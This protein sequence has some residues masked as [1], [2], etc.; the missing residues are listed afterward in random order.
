M[1]NLALFVLIL[2]LLEGSFSFSAENEKLYIETKDYTYTIDKIP[3]GRSPREIEEFHE[4]GL[5]FDNLTLAEKIVFEQSR[6]LYLNKIASILS[7]N[8]ILLGSIVTS[9]EFFKKIKD[10][11]FSRSLEIPDGEIGIIVRRLMQEEAERLEKFPAEKRILKDKGQIAIGQLLQIINH[12]LYKQAKIV[13][14]SDEIGLSL[15]V[16]LG[17]NVGFGKTAAGGLVDVAFLFG[18]N[19]KTKTAVFELH[20]VL[21]KMKKTLTPL[22][23]AGIDLRGGLYIKN[24]NTRGIQKGETLFTP[25]IPTSFSAYPA[26]ADT[27]LSSGIAFP[28]MA[29]ELMG[30]ISTSYRIPLIRIEVHFEPVVSFRVSFGFKRVGSG[31]RSKI[32][33]AVLFAS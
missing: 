6:F 17:L 4:A 9:G 25:A 2:A 16:G 33:C 7:H 8:K 3:Q 26:H 14:A 23:I 20:A 29:T 5:H 12:T 24:S 1:F 13:S 32:R 27:S 19:R 30:Y 28:P 10:I 31:S 22:L 21:E 15:G 18:F 11:I